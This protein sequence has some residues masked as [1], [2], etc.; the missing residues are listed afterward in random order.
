M[1][2]EADLAGATATGPKAGSPALLRST[3]L[4]VTASLALGVLTSWAQDLLPA[5]WASL[6]NSPSGWTIATALVVAL[7]RPDIRRG[8]FF[9]AVGFVCLV[10]GYTLASHLRG[11]PYDP[12][13]WSLIGLVAGPFVGAAAAAVVSRRPRLVALGSGFL[14][15]V[16]VADGIY[17]LTVLSDTTSPV[18]WTAALPAGLSLVAVTAA[19][20][21]RTPLLLAIQI[22]SVATTTAVITLGYAALNAVS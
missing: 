22:A 18:Y 8:A 21:L 6:A 2:T 5:A 4:L 17:G 3:V 1:G 20:R 11:L 16:L 15:G 10:A 7:T 19:V 12:A 9:G 14:A 13:R